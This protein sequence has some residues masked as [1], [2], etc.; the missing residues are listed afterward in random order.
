MVKQIAKQPSSDSDARGRETSRA[1]P[2]GGARLL[3]MLYNNCTDEGL[4]RVVV[5]AAAGVGASGR[6]CMA[7]KRPARPYMTP[8][9]AKANSEA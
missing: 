9:V 4:R 8:G 1:T 2:R 6:C 7:E 5:M 3:G